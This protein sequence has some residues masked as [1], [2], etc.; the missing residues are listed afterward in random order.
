MPVPHEVILRY[1]LDVHHRHL[2]P[3]PPYARFAGARPSAPPY[4]YV[5]VGQMLHPLPAFQAIDG[6]APDNGDKAKAQQ[7]QMDTSF[8]AA[9][10]QITPTLLLVG[11]ATGAAFA[12]GSS[13]VSRYLFRGK[14]S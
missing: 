4:G 5:R 12:I 8:T 10:K 9:L 3:P 14:R 7:A 13:L 2:P 6:E 11:I 1:P